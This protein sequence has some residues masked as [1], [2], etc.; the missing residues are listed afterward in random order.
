M[1]QCAGRMVPG[2]GQAERPMQQTKKP[3]RILPPLKYIWI[4]IKPALPS[5]VERVVSSINGAGSIKFHT[6]NS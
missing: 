1:Q 4:L 2:Q 6:E 3:D 5:S